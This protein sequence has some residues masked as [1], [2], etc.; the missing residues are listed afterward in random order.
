[1][2]C[3]QKFFKS[4]SIP[5]EQ[6]KTPTNAQRSTRLAFVSD[7]RLRSLSVALRPTPVRETMNR[8]LYCSKFFSSY[9]S[10]KDHRHISLHGDLQ[11][12]A[13]ETYCPDLVS[14]KTTHPAVPRQGAQRVAAAY[15]TCNLV[16][17]VTGPPITTSTRAPHEPGCGLSDITNRCLSRA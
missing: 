10:T 4:R 2:W 11:D 12:I 14:R 15:L 7:Y 9:T 3:R 5:S 13:A 16:T 17:G 1:M 6:Q 8:H